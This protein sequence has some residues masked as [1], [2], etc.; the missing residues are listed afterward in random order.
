[1]SF[2]SS[3]RR[4]VL[5]KAISLLCLIEL[6]ALTTL[7]VAP[8]LHERLHHDANQADHHCGVTA[9]AAGKIHLAAASPAISQPASYV[10]AAILTPAPVYFAVDYQ[11]LPGRAP[12]SLIA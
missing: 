6:L 10:I 7:A 11:L 12:P 4:R 9:F 5:L 1:M 3:T 8:G 2:G